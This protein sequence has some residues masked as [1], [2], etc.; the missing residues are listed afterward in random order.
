MGAIH[1]IEAVKYNGTLLALGLQ[2]M[3]LPPKLLDSV[4]AALRV[5]FSALQD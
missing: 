3:D 4:E 2:A 1:L 5:N